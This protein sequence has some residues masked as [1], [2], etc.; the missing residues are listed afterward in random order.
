[1]S[2]KFGIPR[3]VDKIVGQLIDICMIEIDG[4]LA[5]YI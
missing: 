4:E 3:D 2:Q 1:M 5:G